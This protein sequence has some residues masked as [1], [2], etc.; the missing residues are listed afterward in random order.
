MRETIISVFVKQA[1]Q[2]PER[3]AVRYWQNSQWCEISYADLLQQAQATANWLQ[4]L[5]VCTGDAIVLP[6]SRSTGLCSQLLGIL[7]AGAHYVFLDLQYPLQ[8]QRFI[9][10]Q[11]G[12]T[13]GIYAGD[14]QLPHDLPVQ[15]HCIPQL[16]APATTQAIPENAESVAYITFTSG[17]TG[18][19]KG[20]VIPNRAVNRLV[21]NTD[22]ISFAKEQKFLQL[23]ALSFDASTLELWG[24]LL[25][26]GTCVL[27]PQ[28]ETL[29][30]A[31]IR[32]AIEAN[33]VTTLWLTSSLYN[34]I[35]SEHADCL[36]AVKQLLIGGEALSIAHVRKGL[37]A[38]PETR[39][40]NGYGPTENTTFTTVYPIPPMLPEDQNRVPIGFPIN[41]T[42]CGVFD[43]QLKPIADGEAGELI[44]FG[45]GLALEYLNQPDLTAERFVEIE[46]HDGVTRRGYRTGDIVIKLENG[47]YDY[48]QRNDKQVKIDGH[49]IEPGEIERFINA[50]EGVS[51]ARVIVK[52]GPQGQK[53]LAAYVVTQGE[54]DNKVIRAGIAAAFPAFM[55]PHFIIA[56]ADLPKNQNGKLDE[57]RLPD[58]FQSQQQTVASNPLVSRCWLEILGRGNGEEENFFDAGGTSLEALQLTELL[59]KRF[60]RDLGATFVFEYSSI[61]AQAQFFDQDQS[62]PQ[63]VDSVGVNSSSRQDIAVVGIACRFPGANNLDE[64]WDNLVNGRESI[65]FFSDAELS[66]EV[67]AADRNH[68]N[69][70]KAKGIVED[71]DQF[72]AAFFSVSPAEAEVMDPQQRIMLQL[73]WHAME[74]AGYPPGDNK[75]R[76]GVFVG[77]NWSRYFQQ[78]VLN[79]EDVKRKLGA[80]NASLANESDFLSTR[81]SY[82]LDLTGPS[83]NVFTA[84]STGLVAISQACSSIESGDCEMALAGGVSIST[85]VNSGY[86]YQEGSML[87]SDGHCRPFDAAAT[88]TT[89]NDGAGL[90]VLKRLDLARRDGD[91][92]YAVVKGC[93]VNNDGANKASFTAPSVA[94]QVAIYNSALAK[95]GVAA[96]SIGFIETHGTATPLGDPIEVKAL[97]QSYAAAGSARPSSCVIGSVKS[98]IGHTIHAAGVASFIKTVMAVN[99]GL[100]PPTLHF[101]TPNPKLELEKT[102]FYVNN[103]VV[104]WDDALP[105]RAAVSALGVGGTNAHVIVEQ[106]RQP[107][108]ETNVENQFV[109]PH[110]AASIL[111]SAKDK[112]SLELQIARYQQYFAAQP[113]STS[114]TDAAYTSTVGRRHFK[115][116]AAVSGT[117]AEQ[118]ATRLA[119]KKSYVSGQAEAANNSKLCFMFSG[120]GSQR[121]QMGFWLYQH[122]ASFRELIDHGSELVLAQQSFDLRLFIANDGT[123][124]DIGLDVNQTKVAQP[125]L[126]LYEYGLARY[127]QSCGCQPDFLIGHSIGE[128]AAATLAG[129]FSFEDAVRL[130]AARGALMQSMPGGKMLAVNATP[131]AVQD[132]LQTDLCLAAVNAPDRIVL[133]G[134]EDVVQAAKAQ[135]AERKIDGT[136]L[137]TSHAFHSHM[138]QPVVA[139]L[140]ELLA[141]VSLKPPEL[142]IFSTATGR[143]LTADDAIAPSYWSTQLRRPVLFADAITAAGQHYAEQSIAFVEVGPGLA[144]TSLAACQKAMENNTVI[145][146]TP[147]SAQNDDFIGE[148]NQC[149]NSLWVRGYKL[150]WSAQFSAAQASKTRLPGYAFLPTVHWL[151]PPT[152]ASTMTI[153]VPTN[154]ASAQPAQQAMQ[155][156]T[157]SADEHRQVIENKLR[158]LLEDIT[159]FDL[160]DVTA[161]TH[162]S[163]AGLDSLLLTQAA[164]SIEREFAVGLTFRHLV[165]EYT[166]IGELSEFVAAKVPVATS[167]VAVAPV[168][169]AANAEAAQAIAATPQ[170]TAFTAPAGDAV[171]QLIQQQLQVMQLQL[172]ALSGGAAAPAA[173]PALATPASAPA[174]NEPPAAEPTAPASAEKPAARHTPGTRITREIVG[175]NLTKAQQQ[176]LNDV[177]AD[178][179]TKFAKSKQYTQQHRKY[180][181]DPRTVSGFN[182]EWKEIIFPLVTN[183]SKGSRLWDIDGNELIDTS[184][185]FGPIFFG[186]SP[187]FVNAAIKQQIDLG[188]ETGPQSPLAGEVAQLFCELTGN[189]RCTFASSGSEAVMGAIRLARTVTG[190]DKVVMFEGSYHGIFD[191]VLSRPGKNYQALPA[192]PGIPRETTSNMLVVP[193]G[194]PESLETIKS[195][196][197]ELAAVLIEPVQ[198]RKPEFHDKEY[199]QAIRT[200]TQESGSAMILDEVVTGFRVHP[201]GIRKLYDIDADLA[202]YG[203][204]VGGGYPIGIIGGKSRFMDALDGGFW[205]YGDDSIPECGVTFFAGTFVRHPLALAAAKA[206]MQRIKSEGVDLYERLE[207]TTSAMTADAKAFIKDMQ[208]A[209]TFEN[210][211][212]FYYV[213][214]PANAHWGHMLFV[215]MTYEGINM[216]QYRPNF[217]TT[218]HSVEDI[219]KI[220]N[221]FK[222]SLA[223]LICHALIEGDMVAAK[224]YLND[225]P[226]MPTGARL[227]KNARGEPAY[228][229][230]DPENKGNYIE[231]G[232][233]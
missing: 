88:G 84:C 137:H 34:A 117:T 63:P 6:S 177:M 202:T 58:P 185:G 107:D 68:P 198:S 136:I 4:E 165:D 72:D 25:N 15:W 206:I 19:P 62:T 178:Y 204:V 213:A 14:Q 233:P 171:Q 201:G 210:F 48:V 143:Q 191:E 112:Q 18:T 39:I 167:Q 217:V 17:S 161:D 119:Q 27:Y 98:N 190:R 50:L 227:G 134:L 114:V 151:A 216:Q 106:Y 225:K 224:R 214:V 120:Q 148:L 66:A 232:K 77:T 176:W 212:S 54:L 83:I 128:F 173:I 150:D 121:Q 113:G 75:L 215:L 70:V 199:L 208:C 61:N 205:Q 10:T 16:P 32:I 184:N 149:M 30:P 228:F 153:A 116:R 164:M 142:P 7:W 168:A 170:A 24:P 51:E 44:T 229:I 46:C 181:A 109:A 79:N 103:S 163:E 131:D 226:E 105:R 222:T 195:L 188:V 59:E 154:T 138:M 169:P 180:F 74:D 156:I 125:L 99:K 152:A 86:V 159:G 155:E 22:Y 100:I 196:G 45:A 218:E 92:I 21:C 139:E 132:L 187:D 135:L 147:S 69:Y 23:S 71:C 80:F 81:I 192:A 130:V 123:Q 89:F 111:I 223:Q 1:E 90:V 115:H 231:V 87:A 160:D 140:E 35:I 145:A 8:R 67:S 157:M 93:A 118:V 26:G 122:N 73:A 203:K 207:K 55:V 9:C 141:A 179:Q 13:I 220:L 211:A 76:T 162:F 82:K 37:A 126:F 133:S 53:R 194:A 29:T 91:H 102:P 49:R 3:I 78:Y 174:A 20:V 41:G 33:D 209:V 52:T 94:G 183:K 11:V 124:Q 193:W 42:L 5:G 97:S 101:N 38:L 182:P 28:D 40:Y 2:H 95:A 166:T 108:V 172:Q 129:V 12:A 60:E 36:R 104:E 189:E 31:G 65:S 144:L 197:A 43:S 219:A 47:S 110:P 85:P 186:H 56:V 64:Y 221:A 57:G 146:A 200:L 127:L 230:E 175:V 96:D 158:G